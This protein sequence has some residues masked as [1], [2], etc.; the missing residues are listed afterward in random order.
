MAEHDAVVD[1]VTGLLVETGSAPALA[2]ALAR[3]LGDP[4]L[5]R[6]LSTAAQARALAAFAPAVVWQQWLD[7]YHAE[8]GK[9]GS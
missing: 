6:E 1:G 5:R 9:Q 4:A 3:V 2:A 7:L 8:L